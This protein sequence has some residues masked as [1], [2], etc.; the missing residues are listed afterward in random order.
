MSIVP[1]DSFFSS[2]P[3][4]YT[5]TLQRIT[6]ISE[7]DG[8]EIEGYIY[9]GQKCLT[10]NDLSD[11]MPNGKYNTTKKAFQRAI[12]DYNM[13]KGSDYEKVDGE[14]RE[15]FSPNS[16]VGHPIVYLLY[17][18][19]VLLTLANMQRKF[20]AKL[21]YKLVHYYFDS[22][23]EKAK[24]L[25]E[26]KTAFDLPNFS[27]MLFSKNY[28]MCASKNEVII[29]DVFLEIGIPLG[30]CDYFWKNKLTNDSKELLPENWTGINLDFFVKT[31]PLTIVDVQGI[32][33]PSYNFK[34]EIKSKI[35]K[36]EGWRLFVIKDNEVKNVPQL[37]ERIKQYFNIK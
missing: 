12:N 13:K 5:K 36:A 18:S 22:Q 23:D 30:R 7:F 11:Y 16:N 20:K 35:C 26:P 15:L 17:R 24:L 33:N 2:K 19:G 32:D 10:L 3:I 6:F 28:T 34:C 29:V 14:L 37:R 9:Q 4:S 21:L 25:Y 1:L 27:G 8:K 31:E